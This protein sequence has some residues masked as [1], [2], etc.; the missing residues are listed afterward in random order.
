MALRYVDHAVDRMRERG[1][2]LEQVESV[3]RRPIGGAEA[4]DSGN[5]SYVGYVAGG[6]KPVLKVV[7]VAAD[8]ELV[9]TAIWKEAL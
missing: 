9:I 2:T 7:V 3:L 6:A 8:R 4:G 5:V 1:I